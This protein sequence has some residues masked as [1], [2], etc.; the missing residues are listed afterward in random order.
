M[1]FLLLHA[2]IK[3]KQ[4]RQRS[5]T[6]QLGSGKRR[7]AAAKLHYRLHSPEDKQ[8]VDFSTVKSTSL[9]SQ[10]ALSQH[11]DLTTNFPRLS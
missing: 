9:E 11:M 10:H 8:T 4:P 3:K 2:H 6:L 7:L 5:Q 1:S